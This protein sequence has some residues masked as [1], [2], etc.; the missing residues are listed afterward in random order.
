MVGADVLRRPDGPA[1]VMAPEGD[2]RSEVVDNN[3][4]AAVGADIST[5]AAG[6]GS[7]A[8]PDAADHVNM[9]GVQ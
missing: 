5:A 8:E 6:D 7:S 4:V 3:Q 1:A 9:E 2:S